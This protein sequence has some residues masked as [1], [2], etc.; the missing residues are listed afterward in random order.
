MNIKKVAE[1]KDMFGVLASSI[2]PT[3]QG[4]INIK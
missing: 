3:V 1:R 4:H 2:A